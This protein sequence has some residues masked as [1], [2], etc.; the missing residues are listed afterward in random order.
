MRAVAAA[1]AILAILAS[2]VGLGAFLPGEAGPA[3][4]P[5][6][7]GPAPPS[8]H[9]FSGA[10]SGGSRGGLP[11]ALVAEVYYFAIRDDEAIVL[12]NPAPG[13]FDLSGWRLT[14]REGPSEFP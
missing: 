4:A 5:S 11:L 14:D 9:L 12:A 13:A 10:G 2:P 8:P 6:P 1:V 7:V 3:Y